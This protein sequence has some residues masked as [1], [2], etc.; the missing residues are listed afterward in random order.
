MTNPGPLGG[1]ERPLAGPDA[2]PLAVGQVPPPAV[3]AAPA[4]ETTELHDPTPAYDSLAGETSIERPLVVEDVDYEVARPDTV[5]TPDYALAP[6]PSPAGLL[7]AVRDF[8]AKNPVGFLA[9]ALV[10][11]WLVGK[12]FSSSDDDDES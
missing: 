2:D 10:A 5:R 11:G 8:A 12:V 7:A 3:P 6:N 4:Y 1:N 9:G